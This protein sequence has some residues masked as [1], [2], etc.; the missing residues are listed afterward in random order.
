M[1]CSN[2]AEAFSA[3][4]FKDTEFFSHRFCSLSL[5]FIFPML[6]CVYH[7]T[8]RECSLV[9][10]AVFSFQNSNISSQEA[11]PPHVL[12]TPERMW[13]NPLKY[14]YQLNCSPIGV[15]KAFFHSRPRMV[16]QDAY[17]HSDQHHTADTLSMSA[18]D[19]DHIQKTTA[20][21][22]CVCHVVC[23]AWTALPT[24]VS[25]SRFEF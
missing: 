5:H 20:L 2:R 19:K 17:M 12:Q 4:H 22:R 23:A 8:N 16:R 10:D 15:A 11:K 13:N 3:R 18:Q 14:W 24:F 21:S 25:L 1:Q 9:S 7:V 6:T